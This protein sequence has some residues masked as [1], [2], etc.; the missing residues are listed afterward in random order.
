MKQILKSCLATF[1]VLFVLI[2]CSC[3]SLSDENTNT[4]TNSSSLV[5]DEQVDDWFSKQINNNPIDSKF[6][7]D[8]QN[9]TYSYQTIVSDYLVSWREEFDLTKNQ[10]NDFFDNESVA[11]L[12]SYLDNW[13]NSVTQ[14]H[15]WLIED[16]YNNSRATYGTQFFDEEYLKLAKDY[17]TKTIW[18]KWICFIKE[19]NL[20]HN[21]FQD[22][23]KS[24]MWH[25]DIRAE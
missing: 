22:N 8:M 12:C 10:L 20:D 1:I 24:I 7:S 5:G 4:N 17:R 13:E 21:L 9:G 16:V 14:I 18:L 2:C 6:Y 15:S 19:T 23:L 3:S 25:T 11:E